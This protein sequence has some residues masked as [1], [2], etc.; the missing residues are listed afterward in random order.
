MNSL[1][2]S[3]CYGRYKQLLGLLTS[4]HLNISTW[5]NRYM[6]RLVKFLWLDRLRTRAWTQTRWAPPHYY[7]YAYSR[8]FN[9]MIFGDICLNWFN[10]VGVNYDFLSAASRIWNLYVAGLV[11]VLVDILIIWKI[12][13]RKFSG[14]S[15]S[16][17]IWKTQS[18]GECMGWTKRV[19]LGFAIIAPLKDIIGY[20]P[21]GRAIKK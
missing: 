7:S 11:E 21:W 18:L 17:P 3:I 12:R 2:G 9:D 4:Y 1:W 16:Y 14:V 8:I 13:D 19:I 10:L 15:L 6:P 20:G 5:W